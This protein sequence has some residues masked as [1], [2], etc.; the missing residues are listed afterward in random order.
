MFILLFDN[1]FAINNIDASWQL[2]ELV[3]RHTLSEQIVNGIV[4]WASHNIFYRS[5]FVI[6]AILNSEG[7]GRV[8][9]IIECIGD[10]FCTRFINGVVGKP[11]THR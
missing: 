1:L 6:V 8:D 4:G 10:S 2:A 9:T 7:K 5:V 3:G 11:T